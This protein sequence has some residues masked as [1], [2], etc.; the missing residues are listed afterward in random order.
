MEGIT[1]D[2]KVEVRIPYKPRGWCKEFHEAPE[3]WKVLVCHRRS[4]KT[5][6]C[7]N[8]LIRD[9]MKIRNSRFAYIAPY[10]KQAKSIAWDMLKYYSEPIPN[11]KMNESELRIDYPNGSRIQLFGADNPDALRGMALWG[12]IFDEYS[13]QPSSIFTEVIRPCLAD[14]G[15]YAIWIGTPQGRNDFYR[16]FTQ[17]GISDDRWGEMSEEEREEVKRNFYTKMLKASESGILS[18]SEL[19]DAKRTMS[20]DE[21]NQEF[22]CSF[23]ASIKGAY[24]AHQLA[25]SRRLGRICSVPYR[26]DLPVYTFWDLGISDYTSIIFAQKVDREIHIID[27]Y[28]NNGG[29]LEMYATELKKRGYTYAKHFVPHDIRQ[30]ELSTGKSRMDILA[31]SLGADKMAIVPSVSVKD[32]IEALRM[33]FSRLWFDSSKTAYLVDALACYTQEWDDHRGMFKDKPLHNWASHAADAARYL[34]IGIRE[35]DPVGGNRI[36]SKFTK[37]NF[38]LPK[39]LKKFKI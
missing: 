10:Y 39:F 19:A 4:G 24:Y 9:A 36:Q 30:R 5:T 37:S 38:N 14:H 12:V 27:Y 25:D 29:E 20:L 17:Y 3:R 7:I 18:D 15:G 6:A 34:A 22:E 1:E 21:Y 16:M 26:P 28:Q 35:E 23:D 11:T 2:G 31:K 8:H 33:I 32:G 13:Q